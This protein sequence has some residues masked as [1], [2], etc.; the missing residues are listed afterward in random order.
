MSKRYLTFM[1]FF[2]AF[3]LCR[4]EGVYAIDDSTNV[5]KHN[6]SIGL[7]VG[8]IG[9]SIE[10]ATNISKNNRFFGRLGTSY[11]Q[12]QNLF[13]VDLNSKSTINV[14]PDLKFNQI[15][16]AADYYPFKKSSF[17]LFL[18]TSYIYNF[19]VSSFIDTDTGINIEGVE[20]NAEDFGEINLRIDWNKIVPFVG[21]GIGRVVPRRRVGFNFELGCYYMGKPK[22]VSNY[23][24]VLDTTNADELIPII[25][26]NI[27]D[28]S[29]LPFINFKLKFRITK[30]KQ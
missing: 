25:E 12:Y 19:N 21:L 11:L 24:G 10:V 17:H 27:K 5:H 22:I 26:R 18:G 9:P 1:L 20:V 3:Y 7:S 4:N 6:V 30:T 2:F 23:F 13:K 16:L 29:F 15:F 14:E 8:T 28:Y